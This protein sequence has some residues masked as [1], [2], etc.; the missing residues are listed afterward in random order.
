MT[1]QEANR[2]I[3]EF[4]IEQVETYPDLRF[5]QIIVNKSLTENVRIYDEYL[6][7]ENG[8]GVLR[9]NN[10]DYNEE[11]VVTLQRMNEE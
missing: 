7:L 4:L 9:Y 2:K 8:D 1:R 6:A 3:L 11:P 5:N 10:V